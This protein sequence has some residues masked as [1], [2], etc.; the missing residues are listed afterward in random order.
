MPSNISEKHLRRI[1]ERRGRKYYETGEETSRR[2][3]S[4]NKGLLR[5]IKQARKARNILECG[6]GAGST[7]RLLWHKRAQFSGIDI[8]RYAIEKAKTDWRDEDNVFFTVG[9]V[10]KLPFVD[11]SFDFVY[12]AYVME[13]VFNPEKMINEMIRVLKVGGCL[14]L[15]APN[16][17]SPTEFSPCFPMEG[18]K[19]LVQAVKAFLLSHYYLLFPPS[20]LAWNKVRP[21]ILE[22][23]KYFPDSD[24]TVEPYLQTLLTYLEAKNIKVTESSSGL[25]W[26][27]PQD[28]AVSEKLPLSLKFLGFAKKMVKMLGKKGIV[29]YK[30]YGSTLFAMGQKF[31]EDSS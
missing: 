10:E 20:S 18:L 31:D 25:S 3:L 12:S 8:S 1:L 2:D 24:T 16:Y 26:E 17:G 11:N 15:L 14:L 22:T 21:L 28:G 23:K 4:S 7:I 13:H 6:C 30:Y 5:L 29:P 27:A 19:P 9:N